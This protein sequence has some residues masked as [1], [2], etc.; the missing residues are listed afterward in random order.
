[1]DSVTELSQ[2]ALGR[3]AVAEGAA[4]LEGEGRTLQLGD[5][6]VT[7]AGLRE[8]DACQGAGQGCFDRRAGLI[9]GLGGCECSP[10]CAILAP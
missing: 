10:R 3:V 6:A 9:S 2:L 4:F 5:G 8:C 7:L 1:V